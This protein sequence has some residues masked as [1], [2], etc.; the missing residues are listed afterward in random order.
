[1]VVIS[2]QII[3][4]VYYRLA[5]LSEESA[6]SLMDT[7]AIEQPAILAY[8]MANAS[9]LDT[10]TESE[11]MMFT[12]VVLWQCFK[13]ANPSLAPISEDMVDAKEQANIELMQRMDEMSMNGE[14]DSVQTMLSEY[15]QEPLLQYALSAL[16]N[17]EDEEE[18][19]DDE[20]SDELI[21]EEA[22]G[23]M[24]IVFKTIIDSFTASA[25]E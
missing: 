12:G 23:I 1:M 21:G 11:I 5:D 7:M 25:S 17:E 16:T 6:G 8:L 19:E 15:P 10:D 14:A 22:Q 9:E 3:N 24:L 18:N 13:E 4:D 20:L 2:D